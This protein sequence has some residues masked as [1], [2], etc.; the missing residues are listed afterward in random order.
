MDCACCILGPQP[1]E[2]QLVRSYRFAGIEVDAARR[3]VV[4]PDGEPRQLSA[5]AFDVLLHL[6]ENRHR[7]VDKQELMQAAW[8]RAGRSG[9]AASRRGSS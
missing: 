6:V 4:G 8:P 9:T 5:R 7:V 2:T 1:L 3:R